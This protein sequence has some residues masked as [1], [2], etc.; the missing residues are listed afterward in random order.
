MA[1]QG[2][3]FIVAAFYNTVFLC[4]KTRN[5]FFHCV[6]A[7][8]VFHALLHSWCI[9][10]IKFGRPCLNI[11]FVIP[12]FSGLLLF[13]NF[14]MVFCISSTSISLYHYSCQQVV[15]ICLLALW[16]I[17]RY[18]LVKLRYVEFAAVRCPSLS[19]VSFIHEK[20]YCLWLI[21]ALVAIFC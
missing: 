13:L 4:S 16:H 21:F 14:F 12:L 18:L 6:G 19:Y 8:P 11:S 7:I 20:H 17:I 10:S 5:N 15:A 3:R 1:C 9:S 2:N